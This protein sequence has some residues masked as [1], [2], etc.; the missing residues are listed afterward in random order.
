MDYKGAIAD[1]S[2][3]IRLKPDDVEAYYNQGQAQAE[4]KD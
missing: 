4:I 3:L 2:E 1:S